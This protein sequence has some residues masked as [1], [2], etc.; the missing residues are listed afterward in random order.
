MDRKSTTEN[1]NVLASV[2]KNSDHLN[3]MPENASSIIEEVGEIKSG[4]NRIFTKGGAHPKTPKKAPRGKSPTRRSNKNSHNPTS[5]IKSSPKKNKP[6]L[7]FSDGAADESKESIPNVGNL[8]SNPLDAQQ[9]ISN[10]NNES[11]A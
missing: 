5:K 8:I 9:N 6:R 10:S 4:R 2:Q 3:P 1:I 7:D 11:R